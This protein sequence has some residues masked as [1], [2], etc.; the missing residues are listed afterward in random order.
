MALL[1]RLCDSSTTTLTGLG[2]DKR[3]SRRENSCSR[4]IALPTTLMLHDRMARLARNVRRPT[5]C[6]SSCVLPPAPRPVPIKALGDKSPRVAAQQMSCARLGALKFELPS[7]GL[8]NA[9]GTARFDI[10]KRG[11]QRRDVAAEGALTV[12]TADESI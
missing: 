3:S 9:P 12:P 1:R 7:P 4:E 10:S 2:G 5:P 11:G 8:E 6:C